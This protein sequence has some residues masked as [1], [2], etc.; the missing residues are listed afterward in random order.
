MDF[1]VVY[2]KKADGNPV[3]AI[4]SQRFTKAVITLQ[5]IHPEDN[6]A[7]RGVIVV[8]GDIIHNS[9]VRKYK[10]DR[11]GNPV[12][13]PVLHDKVK[14]LVTI[15]DSALGQNILVFGE[16]YVEVKS[17]LD[18]TGKSASHTAVNPEKG[19][20][21]VGSRTGLYTVTCRVDTGV[22]AP[23]VLSEEKNW[24]WER[25]R[26]GTI[27]GM[28]LLQAPQPEPNGRNNAAGA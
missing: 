26:N 14:D 13:R 5:D 23:E 24:E 1:I 9:V 3:V 25:D 10:C 22:L 4:H 18:L 12:L 15:N 11:K 6:A 8:P 19:I 2:D 21:G 16:P 27:V 7:E 17:L 20:I 28:K